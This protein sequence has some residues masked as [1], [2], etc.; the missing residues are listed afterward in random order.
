MR[1]VVTVGGVAFVVEVARTVAEQ[2]AGL[3]DRDELREGTG[4][5]FPQSRDRIPVF[6]MRRMRF[7]LDF[8]W[9]AADCT[10]AEVTPDVPPPDEGTLTTNL[11]TY[12]PSV[13]V[14]YVLEINAGAAQADGLTPGDPVRFSGRELGDLSCSTL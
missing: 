1:P 10:L 3:S 7:P 5:L 4:M 13:P 14:R 9:I 12:S 11:P 8:L 2:A 6:W